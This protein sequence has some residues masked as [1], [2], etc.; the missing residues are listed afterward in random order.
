MVNPKSKSVRI[1]TIASGK[2]GVGKTSI[3]VNLAICLARQAG[4]VC[5]LDADLGLANVDVLLGISPDYSLMDFLEKKCELT[6]LLVD[7]P[8]LLKIIPGGTALERLPDLQSEEKTRL[9]DVFQHLNGYETIITDAS[10]GISEQVLHLLDAASV[11]IIVI[12]P[13]PTSLTDAYSLIKTYHRKGCKGPVFILVNQVKS[14]QHAERVYDKFK[15]VVSKYLDVPLK[16]IGYLLAD[17]SVQEAVTRQ[18]PLVELFHD[19][20][21]TRCL[22]RISENL[23]SKDENWAQ[24]NNLKKLFYQVGTCEDEANAPDQISSP[25]VPDEKSNSHGEFEDVTSLL[26]KEGLITSSQVDYARKVQAKL[27]TPRALIPILKNLGYLGEEQIKETL[28][29]NRTRIR[30]GSLLVDLGY[31]SDKQLEMALRQ[32][33]ENNGKK[34]LGEILVHD[35]YITE[36]EL[37]QMLSINLGIPYVEP[38]LNMIDLSLLEKASQNF[39]Q[40]YGLIPLRVEGG[41]TRVA[42]TDPLNST[43]LNAAQQIF[44]RNLEIFITMGKYIKESLESYDFNKNQKQII[45]PDKSEV[46]QIVDDIIVEALKQQASDIHLEP[47]KNRTRVRFRRDGTLLHYT[48][49]SKDLESPIV[50]RIKVMAGANITEKR[51]HQDGRI[52]LASGQHNEEI[53]IRVSFYITLFGEKVVMR[54]L[55]KKAELFKINDLGLGQKMLER[56]RESVLDLPSG[57]VI[58]TGPT[59]AG[60]TTTLYASINYCNNIDS[61]IITAEEPVEYVIEGVSQCSIDPK[62]GLTFEE[63][64]RHMLRQDPDIIIL[65][66]IRDRFSA[67]SAIQAA[68]TGHKVIT[69]FHTEDSIGGLLRLMNMDIEAFLISS[70]VVCVVAQRLLKKICPYCRKSYIPTARDLRRLQYQ[71]QNIRG[72]HFHIGGGC[73]ECDF[74]GYRGRIGVFEMLILSEYVKEALLQRKTSYE[75]RRISMETTGLVTLLEDG[76]AKAAKG[77]T[78]IPEVIKSLPLLEPPRSLEQINR[79][80]GEV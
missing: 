5:L 44:G 76:L 24:R 7:G 66:E 16:P 30:L 48:D 54:I 33:Q 56:F 25:D 11:P 39:F 38:A 17:P 72:H 49:I 19:S 20:P 71:P 63:T 53:D 78:S 60:K 59:G 37:I 74:T 32:Q 12:V 28:F 51:R 43:A 68:L 34:R 52:L 29:K 9:K 67:E 26:V 4:P 6:D 1:I 41:K 22:L 36:Y 55:N 42:I 35:N 27:D 64:L 23:S 57:V 65:G 75:I 50:S 61:N 69:T 58:I 8:G 31:I 47:L 13:E 73:N 21:A 62:I 45:K 3:A 15:E 80:I 70:T 10:A 40:T 18:T 77:Q 46:V 2:G 14:S 79:L